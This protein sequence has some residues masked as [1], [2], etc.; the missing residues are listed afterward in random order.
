MI[1]YLII[2][3]AL[4]ML[5]MSF[6]PKAVMR[7]DEWDALTASQK[8]RV[9]FSYRKG[10]PHD[11]GFTLAAIALNESSAGKY[12][13]VFRT[14]DFG[15]YHLN[16]KT[17]EDMHPDLGYY[18]MIALQQDLIYNDDKAADLAIKVLQHFQGSFDSWKKV[19]K[20]Y[21]RGY[22]WLKEPEQA[23]IAE[24]YYSK[25]ASTVRMLRTCG[26]FE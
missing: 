4:C 1:K 18:K 5:V 12:R 16:A 3:A 17:V 11:L 2:I 22:R 21:N 23:L 6:K 26:D 24:A 13:V 20:S 15:L 7:C 9:E 19:V 8:D 25:I 14:R 10:Q